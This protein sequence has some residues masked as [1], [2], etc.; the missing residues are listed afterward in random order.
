MSVLSLPISLPV[1][2]S[3]PDIET[4]RLILRGPALGDFDAYA[5]FMATD[6]SRMTGGP[7]DRAAAWRSFACENGH[8]MLRGYGMWTIVDKASG[9]IAGQTGF[10]NP[11]GWSEVELG[12]RLFD[13]F[14][15]RGLAY[16][17]ALAA[18]DYAYDTL[19]WGAL[20]SVIA[21]M[22][23]RS[24]RLAERMGAQL[25]QA[26]WKTPSGKTG[27]IYRHVDPTARGA[28]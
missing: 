8:W 20:T 27:R 2:L 1:S 3:I 23:D 4:D 26:D 18:R 25:E 22:N 28:K 16:E 17:A 14:E 11:E 5:E 15:G 21:P 9:Q 24:I 13:G 10:W 6:R 12:W 19:G 7:L